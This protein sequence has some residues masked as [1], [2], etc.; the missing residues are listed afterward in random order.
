MSSV[1]SRRFM[2]GLSGVPGQMMRL[3]ITRRALPTTLLLTLALTIG[4]T[5]YA[6]W[7]GPG[8]GAGSATTGTALAVTLTPG[9]PTA[10]LYPGGQTDVV[11]SVS[12][13]NAFSVRIG[14]FALANGQGTG[15]FAV[16]P[17]HLASGCTVVAA[18]LS[19][20]SSSGGWTVPAS[21]SLPVVLTS[22][23]G[24]GGAAASACQGASFTVYLAAGP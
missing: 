9:T 14:S 15:G 22:K 4:G 10:A 5:A 16:D 23:L 18:A 8:V 13:P 7:S 21:G 24:I 2:L 19:L 11:L 6:H 12:N 17:G 1:A 20:T 3:R